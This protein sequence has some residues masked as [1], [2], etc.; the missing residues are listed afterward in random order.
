MLNKFFSKEIFWWWKI[1]WLTK[2]WFLEILRQPTVQLYK[3]LQKMVNHPSIFDFDCN[4]VKF[5]RQS[6]Q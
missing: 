2:R 1:Y 5:S 4:D 6:P 3:I